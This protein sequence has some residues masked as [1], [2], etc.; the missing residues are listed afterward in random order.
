MSERT[1]PRDPGVQSRLQEAADAFF[2]RQRIDDKD[3]E[4]LYTALEDCL[5]QSVGYDPAQVEKQGELNNP[6][7]PY[8]SIVDIDIH[9][10]DSKVVGHVR[11]WE[12]TS[13]NRAQVVDRYIDIVVSPAVISL[14]KQRR[15]E[16]AAETEN[17]EATWKEQS[18]V[19]YN[20]L[21]PFVTENEGKTFS[22]AEWVT[23]GLNKLV[24]IP[25]DAVW[26][27]EMYKYPTGDRIRFTVYKSSKLEDGVFDIREVGL[28]E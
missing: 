5:V 1:E 19:L 2:V 18:R 10:F 25:P 26:R 24:E 9:G 4:E 28:D 13:D 21:L 6:N 7:K 8:S 11:I 22:A 16:Q 3:P 20:E 12:K 14:E 15:A 17:Q 23:R 27:V